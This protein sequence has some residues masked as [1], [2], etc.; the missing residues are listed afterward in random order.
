[1]RNRENKFGERNSKIISLIKKIQFISKN[2]RTE[3]MSFLAL[4]YDFKAAGTEI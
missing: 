4:N 2:D 3:K 1:M